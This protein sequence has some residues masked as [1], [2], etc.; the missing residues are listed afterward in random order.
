[1]RRKEARLKTPIAKTE[2][3][4]EIKLTNSRGATRSLLLNPDCPLFPLQVSYAY[5]PG[6]EDALLSAYGIEED[7][8]RITYYR[9]LWNLDD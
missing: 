1:M 2:R 8:E 4:Q 9:L 3:P 6:W 7:R 5:G